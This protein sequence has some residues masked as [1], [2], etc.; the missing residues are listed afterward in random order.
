MKDLKA[1]LGP[2]YGE[3]REDGA[4][5]SLADAVET[6]AERLGHTDPDDE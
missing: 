5:L 3:L 2:A 6:A 4:A 1:S